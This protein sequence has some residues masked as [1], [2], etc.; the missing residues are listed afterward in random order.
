MGVQT[1]ICKCVRGQKGSL[2]LGL[3]AFLTT[4]F[5]QS[6]SDTR[7]PPTHPAPKP[8]LHALACASPTA[9]LLK[10]IFKG[11]L[12]ISHLNIFGSQAMPRPGFLQ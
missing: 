2:E 3:D 6:A 11:S 4:L 8:A 12:S 10:T 5:A 1:Q 7:D 9:S